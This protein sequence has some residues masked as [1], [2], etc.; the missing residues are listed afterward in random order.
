MAELILVQDYPKDS[1]TYQYVYISLRISGGCLASLFPAWHHL[2]FQIIDEDY[3][4]SIYDSNM[5]KGGWAS[6]SGVSAY[7]QTVNYM[8]D[9]EWQRDGQVYNELK[10]EYLPR[11]RKPRD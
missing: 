1:G 3:D 5:F 8:I 6:S 2:S 11:Y 7:N 4:K 10:R 9:H